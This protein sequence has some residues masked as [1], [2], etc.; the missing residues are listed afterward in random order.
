M[1]IYGDEAERKRAL[2]DLESTLL[3][4]AA[5]G[6][7]KTSLLAGRVV[8]LLASGVHPRNIAAITF[9]ELAAGE[10]KVRVG[11]FVK[12]MLAGEVPDDLRL[13]LPQGLT[14]AQADAL[15]QAALSLDEMTSAT[16]HG[17]CH[18]LLLSYSV[19]ADVDPGAQV[20]DS[21]QSEFAFRNVFDRWL[22]RRLGAEGAPN[23]P[24]ALMARRDP[25]EAVEMLSDLGKFRRRFRSAR[26]LASTLRDHA[27]RDFIEAVQEFRR[28]FS[29]VSGPAAAEADLIALE[30][31]A[32]FYQ[33]A[34][35]PVPGIERLWQLA[36]PPRVTVMYKRS[37]DLL[38]YR[39]RGAWGRGEEAEKR[40]S[41]AV[42]H[43]DSC[44]EAFRVL[45]GQLATHLV[46]AF[47]S[48][49][50]ELLNDFEAFKRSAA[51]LDFDD[52]LLRTR[53]LLNEHETVRCAAARRF[54]RILVDE[55]Q[56]TDP[57][58]SEILFL[59]AGEPGPSEGWRSRRLLPGH[60]FLVGDPKQ[61]IYRFR[62]A[63]IACYMQVR[64]AIEQA[65]C[66]H[67]LRVTS[68]FR[69]RPAI[70]SHVNLCF[71]GP[72]GDQA[73]VYVPLKA[74]RGDANH[75]LPCIARVT[76]PVSDPPEADAIR[77]QE[78][79]IIADICARLTGNLEIE[80]PDGTKTVLA[81]GDI[82]LLAP[83]GTQLWRYER[84]LEERELP[85]VSQAG[86]SLFRRQE[87]Q[88]FIAIARALADGRDTLALGALLRGPIVGLTE[89]ELLDVAAALPA[90][91]GPSEA[92]RLSIYTE[93]ELINHRVA[94]E[95]I[96]V[97]R[98]LRR[99]ARDTTPLLLLGEALERLHVRPAIE[100]RSS[101]QASR[102]LANL[103]L[104]LE[105]S[106]AYAVGGISRFA[107]D[108]KDD[109]T[110]SRPYDEARIDAYGEAI[111]IITVHSAKGLEW[112]VVIPINMGT[113]FPPPDRF[114]YRRDDDTLHW[115]LGRIVPPALTDAMT[116][117]QKESME[118][119][120]RLLYVACTRAMDLLIVP[121]L[122]ASAP[123]CWATLLNLKQHD[124]PE[125]SIA[126]LQPKSRLNLQYG[127]ND[128]TRQKFAREQDTAAA[129]SIPIR[130]IRPSEHD[131]DR[132]NAD[133]LVF[134][135]L[136]QVA[137]G[138]PSIE[139]STVR[140]SILHKLLEE[141]LTGELDEVQSAVQ[142]RARQL[143]V[144]FG[145]IPSRANAPDADELARTAL[146]TL[147]LPGI[148]ERRQRIVPEMPI[149][150]SLGNA[151]MLLS[152]RADAVAFEGDIPEI[153]FDWKSDVAP[154]DTDR[155]AYGAQLLDYVKAIGAKR[156]A[157]V[158]ISLGQINWIE[159]S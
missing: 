158:Y 145:S 131:R 69:S 45:L 127:M 52:L 44:A 72:L 85:F 97:L 39:R 70:L 77:D 11:R 41:K 139:G 156:G 92:P 104:L 71:E 2:T 142:S 46:A 143:L 118:E 103:N 106:R 63:D 54:T 22:G 73:Q 53:R 117:E 3:V 121:Q 43:Y 91:D 102:A 132:P 18:A 23:D 115:T 80:R 126:R 147:S 144:Q 148:T 107:R 111:E 154:T 89:E 110:F 38:A 136:E 137:E 59:L 119:G 130:W 140:G 96:G 152:G 17:F 49:S 61:A 55:F 76:I 98:E 108:L 66:G 109:W 125:L 150:A 35:A 123:K 65:F 122:S 75:G 138:I 1:T 57:V 9:T 95:I 82:A 19:E 135:E 84:A 62:G 24:I 4:E 157:V 5:A 149:Y 7:G 88:D 128:Q 124:L 100:L 134:E 90:D 87:A 64:N 60:L 36:H 68:N 50:D 34:F 133:A 32:A 94:R 26:P 105:R 151:A 129:A 20:L 28:W 48:E 146:R 13:A 29:N 114:I 86:K 15:R 6:T 31:L 56:D 37:F 74:T 21:T 116:V 155:T 79:K 141:L 14:S 42:W 30:Q 120:E 25:E 51:L 58:Q 83:A 112:P 78:A 81:P 27:D 113:Q 40:A 93:P 12:Q 8:M 10:L 16:I 99:K 47:S 67:V 153:V 101:D 33:G 159:A